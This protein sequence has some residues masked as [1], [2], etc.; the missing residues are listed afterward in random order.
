MYFSLII[1]M[2]LI[3]PL[4]IIPR[5]IKSGIRS[6]YNIIVKSIITVSAM[7]ALIFMGA[8]MSGQDVYSEVYGI[9]E[10][11]AEEAAANEQMAEAFGMESD[12][13]DSRVK[14]LM[15]VYSHAL[16]Q[17]PACLILIAAVV[18]YLEYMML[19][20]I[21]GR[22]HSVKKLPPFR[23]FSFPANSGMAVM[24]MLLLGILMYEM[25]LEIGEMMYLN[26]NLIFDM[27]FSIQGISVILMYF[28]MK[29]SPKVLGIGIAAVLWITYIG[30]LLLMILGILDLTINLKKRIQGRG[31]II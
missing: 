25:D 18:S 15:A 27:I 3:M 6:P 31:R 17:L 28:H 14:A 29:R 10:I 1:M 26:M 20:K 9:L 21:R 22:K 8:S 5:E 13:V 7:I 19:A 11:G 30:R 4:L 2:I 23:E 24:I 16:K 12:S